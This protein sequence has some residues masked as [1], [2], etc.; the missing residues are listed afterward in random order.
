MRR[1]IFACVIVALIAGA[2]SAT[3]ANL[4]TGSDVKNGSLTGA[5]I[6]N[7]AIDSED[8][9]KG[10]VI[11]KKLSKAVRDALDDN[12]PAGPQGPAGPPGPGG[13]ARWTPGP[14]AWGRRDRPAT[15]RTPR[16]AS[17]PSL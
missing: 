15:P 7:P 10:A 16:S 17:P 1:T 3:A 13:G 11:K 12:G 9:K 4:I 14:W 8:I 6:K 5:D 2:T